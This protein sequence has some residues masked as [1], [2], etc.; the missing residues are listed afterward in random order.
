[1]SHRS[2]LTLGFDFRKMGTKK[3]TYTRKMAWLWC[4]KNWKWLNKVSHRP[5]LTFV[6]SEVSIFEK[7]I[8]KMVE[9]AVFPSKNV[10]RGPR[11]AISWE[12]PELFILMQ[13]TA[14]HKE[15][16]FG[17]KKFSGVKS[18]VRFLTEMDKKMDLLW[19]S[20]VKGIAPQ[21]VLK[22][23]PLFSRINPDILRK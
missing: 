9:S 6:N 17:Y 5:H 10:A 14:Q 7:W 12:H 19:K 21:E 3:G 18:Q 16:W 4:P 23:I 20:G 8:L 13:K 22:K 11:G 15:E 1:M 2:L